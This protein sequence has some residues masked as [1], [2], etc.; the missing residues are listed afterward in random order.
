M[1]KGNLH[2][3]V[4]YNKRSFIGWITIEQNSYN[5][6]ANSLINDIF[7][8]KFKLIRQDEAYQIEGNF[9]SFTAE[10]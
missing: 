8:G 2:R 1:L 5:S 9:E 3:I 4:I 10:N 7:S 6:I